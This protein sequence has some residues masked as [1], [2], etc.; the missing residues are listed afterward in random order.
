ML[1]S[2]MLIWPSSSSLRTIWTSIPINIFMINQP[3]ATS[4]WPNF[5][6]RT[7]TWPRVRHRMDKK[8]TSFSSFK[9]TISVLP[10][11]WNT[12]I[13]T[14]MSLSKISSWLSSSTPP[15]Q[16]AIFSETTIISD[17]AKCGEILDCND[18]H[19]RAPFVIKLVFKKLLLPSA[20]DLYFPLNL[21]HHFHSLTWYETRFL[22]LPK[23]RIWRPLFFKIYLY[24]Y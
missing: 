6:S 1:T 2:V 18:L 24:L 19:Y 12:W 20:N 9:T 11:S 21:A 17:G 3:T 13:T 8:W 4:Q 5:C 23:C 7:Q 22:S 16:L 15:P 10:N 14:W